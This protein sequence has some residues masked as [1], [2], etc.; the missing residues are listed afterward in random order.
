MA[1]LIVFQQLDEDFVTGIDMSE[2]L[3][4]LERV[5]LRNG[6]EVFFCNIHLDEVSSESPYAYF[7]HFSAAGGFL[8]CIRIAGQ[9]YVA[10]YSLDSPKLFRFVAGE[11]TLQ[12]REGMF[13][14]ADDVKKCAIA[15]CETATLY[16][17]INWIKYEDL[18]PPIYA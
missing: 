10:G 6:N 2:L 14:R 3:G 17:H 16:P 18:E 1:H 9:V 11:H 4:V 8:V 5:E 7:A 13:I 12:A 15:F